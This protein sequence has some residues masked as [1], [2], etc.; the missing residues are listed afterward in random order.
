MRNELAVQVEMKPERAV[1]VSLKGSVDGHTFNG[2]AERFSQLP[3]DT[4][5]IVLDL[6]MMDYISSVGV[7]FLVRTRVLQRK[8]GGD[9]I[10]VRPQPQVHRILKMLGLLEVLVVSGTVEEAWA[11]VW[12][13]RGR[14]ASPDGLAPPAEA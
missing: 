8:A 9:C 7:N 1:F 2:L 3:P 4:L 10:L 12:D 5:W 11:E 6:S 13:R 14:A